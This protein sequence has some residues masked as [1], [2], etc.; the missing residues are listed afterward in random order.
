MC[1]QSGVRGLSLN[2]A[3][4]HLDLKYSWLVEFLESGG[5]LSKRQGQAARPP[6]R[7]VFLLLPLLLGSLHADVSVHF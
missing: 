2:K 4:I 7:F 1:N 5:G 6:S 3:G